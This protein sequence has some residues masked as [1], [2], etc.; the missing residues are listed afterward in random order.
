MPLIRV[1]CIICRLY[2]N[3]SDCPSRVCEPFHDSW[4]GLSSAHWG[5][6]GDRGGGRAA[7]RV[8]RLRC[9]SPP[10]DGSGFSNKPQV[11]APPPAPAEGQP[12][13][14]LDAS[15]GDLFAA[16]AGSPP[17]GS[18]GGAGHQFRTDQPWGEDPIHAY[19][20]HMATRGDPGRAEGP[21]PRHKGQG[22]ARSRCWAWVLGRAHSRHPLL[23]TGQETENRCP[24]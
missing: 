1:N 16:P 18:R 22:T 19:H 7:G 12:H 4:A 24:C 21:L 23:L 3:K 9:R 8:P 6:V 17:S 14:P 15:A 10:A 11:S 13:W 5:H 20:P 2:P